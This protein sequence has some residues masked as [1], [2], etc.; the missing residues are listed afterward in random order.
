MKLIFTFLITFSLVACGEPELGYPPIA[1]CNPDSSTP[2]CGDT[3]DP[4]PEDNCVAYLGCAAICENS[5]CTDAC[6]LATNAPV[7]ECLVEHCAG[8]LDACNRGFT[9]ACA[10]LPMCGGFD[11][12]DN[13]DSGSGSSGESSSDA[14]DSSGA[15]SSSSSGTGSSGSPGDSSTN[16][17]D[18]SST[19]DTE[20]TS[21]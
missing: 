1:M 18:G 14:G 9:D 20:S 11:P 10:E 2:G 5:A 4:V 19:T 8:L 12:S 21:T 15:D 17:E 13:S 7:T 6:A 3:P 16:G